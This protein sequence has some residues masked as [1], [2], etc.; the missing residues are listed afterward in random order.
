M[1]N[2]VPS[3]P[4]AAA[5]PINPEVFHLALDVAVDGVT[6]S[7]CVQTQLKFVQVGVWE[8]RR[9]CLAGQTEELDVILAHLDED[10]ELLRRALERDRR[11]PE[12]GKR[13]A[14]RRETA[15]S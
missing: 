14:R 3:R 12:T 5:T 4:A 6:D 13:K 15:L 1:Q 11:S 10:V 9:R 2:P 8:A 7:P